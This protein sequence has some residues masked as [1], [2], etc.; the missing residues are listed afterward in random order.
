MG[1]LGQYLIVFAILAGKIM[2]AP[3][4]FLRAMW[5]DVLGYW[6]KR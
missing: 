5:V 3:I 6:R 1:R 4:R 2:F